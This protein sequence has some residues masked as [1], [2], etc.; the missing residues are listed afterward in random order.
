MATLQKVQAQIARLQAQAETLVAKQSSTVIEKI[1]TLMLEHGLTTADIDMHTG[2]RKKRGRKPGVKAAAKTTGSSAKYRDPKTG[3][4]WTGHG[5]APA[6]IANARDRTRFLIDGSATSPNVTVGREAKAAPKRVLA[7]VAKADGKLPP[8][9]R[10]PK[11]GATW[12][13]HARPPT[14]IKDV[15]DR[16]KFL[17]AGGVEA[18]VTGKAGTASKAKAV[19]KKAESE[20]AGVAVSKR[21]PTTPPPALYREPKSGATW[22][23]RGRAPAWLASVKN[24]S[25]FLIE[26]AAA[27][28]STASDDKASGSTAADR[29]GTVATKAATRKAAA[30]NSPVSKKAVS[31]VKPV[32]ANKEKSR[33]ATSVKIDA[34]NVE[35]PVAPNASPE[36]V[37]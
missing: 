16:S 29:K 30:A 28:V 9:Y 36:V 17:I 13:G 12:S 21:Q 4:A 7:T 35:V 34:P 11:T 3:A 8:K 1:R 5:R 27:V 37:A 23:G 18:T 25:P 15:K 26:G 24:R 14:W 31:A 10:D 2:G 22:S 20:P 6:W 19:G 33:K 32:I